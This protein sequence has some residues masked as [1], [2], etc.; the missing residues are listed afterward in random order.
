MGSRRSDSGAG[1]SRCCD[2]TTPCDPATFP[3]ACEAAEEA[4]KKLTVAVISN[5]EATAGLVVD[6]LIGMQ[7]AVLKSLSGIFS[8]YRPLG[9]VSWGMGGSPSS[10]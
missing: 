6:D 3:A 8:R 4:T 9:R 1:S 7:E 10:P 5:R 2:S